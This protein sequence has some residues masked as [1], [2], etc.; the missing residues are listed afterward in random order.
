MVDV[1]LAVAASLV[2]RTEA[3]NLPTASGGAET[4]TGGRDDTQLRASTVDAGL[5]PV[6]PRRHAGLLN[7]PQHP[8][9]RTTPATARHNDP[10]DRC[11]VAG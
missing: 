7:I 2:L 8:Y 9:V 1:Y 10:A 11:E 3:I 6:Q 5:D 4:R